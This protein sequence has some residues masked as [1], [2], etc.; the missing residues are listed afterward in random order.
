LNEWRDLMAAPLVL[1]PGA[2]RKDSRQFDWV[3]SYLPALRFAQQE[4][5]SQQAEP[6]EQQE[7]SPFLAALPPDFWA[8][9]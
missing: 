4:P 7:D 6:D 8:D 3:I 9:F 2:N 5:P 1:Q